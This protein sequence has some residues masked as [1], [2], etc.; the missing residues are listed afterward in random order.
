MQKYYY[1]TEVIAMSNYAISFNVIVYE[2]VR[3]YPYDTLSLG[4]VNVVVYKRENSFNT[5]CSSNRLKCTEA[6]FD[7]IMAELSKICIERTKDF[8]P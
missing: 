3:T 5:T 1:F 4:N 8:F 6:D 7:K 2:F